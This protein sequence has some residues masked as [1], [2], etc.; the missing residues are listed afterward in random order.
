MTG[1]SLF[2]SGTAGEVHPDSH[3]VEATLNRFHE[4]A[5]KA[6]GASYFALF[7]PEAVFI[8]RRRGNPALKD[9]VETPL[10]LFCLTCLIVP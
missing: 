5:S 4:A 9:R 8:D 3:E 1:G 10:L 7:A 2:G 6:D